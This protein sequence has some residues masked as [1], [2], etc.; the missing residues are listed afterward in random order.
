MSCH[1]V[2]FERFVS[3][4]DGNDFFSG[5]KH[6]VQNKTMAFAIAPVYPKNVSPISSSLVFSRKSLAEHFK[7]SKHS[8]SL[9][10][11]GLNGLEANSTIVGFNFSFTSPSQSYCRKMS[12]WIIF[13]FNGRLRFLSIF[14]SNCRNFI[15]TVGL[16]INASMLFHL[17]NSFETRTVSKVFEYY[18]KKS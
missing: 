18:S 7:F 15:C 8:W 13:Q 4:L 17:W 6:I 5:R 14:F 9:F 3:F 16:I 1:T 10:S 2:V 12:F 11:I